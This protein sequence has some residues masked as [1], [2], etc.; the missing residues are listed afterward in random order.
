[1][2]QAVRT[3]AFRALAKDIDYPAHERSWQG[4]ISSFG[5]Q[6]SNGVML[7]FVQEGV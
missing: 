3:F 2:C 4:T 5:E 6:G 1:M 7:R